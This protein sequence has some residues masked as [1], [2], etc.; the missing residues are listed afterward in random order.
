MAGPSARGRLPPP[1]GPKLAFEFPQAVEITRSAE[2]NISKDFNARRTPAAR[3]ADDGDGR[4]APPAAT[5]RAA[6]TRGRLGRREF[7]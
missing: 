7:A 4:F 2:I 6:Q 5:L 1:G 3:R